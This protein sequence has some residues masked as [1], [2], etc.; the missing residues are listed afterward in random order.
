MQDEQL[1]EEAKHLLRV[2]Y[3]QR[4]VRGT[5][6]LAAVGHT[7]LDERLGAFGVL[8]TKARNEQGLST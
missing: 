8:H 3:E 7:L 2:A 6:P 5:P 1:R 4:A